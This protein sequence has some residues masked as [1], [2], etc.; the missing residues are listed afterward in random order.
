MP[1]CRCAGICD[2]VSG[3][4]AREGSFMGRG[5]QKR[6]MGSGYLLTKGQK[7][8]A[9]LGDETCGLR[10]FFVFCGIRSTLA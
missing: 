4:E 7:L 9:S 3:K 5:M 6:A 8:D 1:V 10:H 2:T